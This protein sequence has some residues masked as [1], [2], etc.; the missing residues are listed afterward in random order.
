MFTDMTLRDLF[1]P[2]SG[3]IPLDT[4]FFER[5]DERERERETRSLSAALRFSRMSRALRSSLLAVLPVSFSFRLPARVYLPP[6]T[7]EDLNKSLHGSIPLRN[8]RAEK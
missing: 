4:S 3:K 6:G 7:V 8:G 2:F 1:P 5:G